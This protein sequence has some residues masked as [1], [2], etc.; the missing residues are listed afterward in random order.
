MLSQV[1]PSAGSITERRAAK[2]A[3]ICAAAC[4][5][6]NL[7]AA[8]KHP[9][10]IVLFDVTRWLTFLLGLALVLAAIRLWSFERRAWKLAMILAGV[11]SLA[12]LILYRDVK[13][14]VCPLIAAGALWFSRSA[15]R[16]SSGQR[17]LSGPGRKA[18]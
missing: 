9:A 5:V 10:S 2:A 15:F 16:P 11:S 7:A 14:A 8:L 3:A 1:D 17:R 18:F 6:L 12:Q 4:G 13:V